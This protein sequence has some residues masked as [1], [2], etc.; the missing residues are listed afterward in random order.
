MSWFGQGK[1][2]DDG[3]AGSNGN[4]SGDQKELFL[5]GAV[6]DDSLTEGRGFVLLGGAQQSG[7][8]T[9]VSVGDDG[10]SY[11]ASGG[12]RHLAEVPDLLP[13]DDQEIHRL[14]FQHH[15][16]RYTMRGNFAAPISQ[17]TSILDV[18]CGTGRWAIEMAGLFPTANVIGLDIVPPSTRVPGYAERLPENFLFVNGN[19]F[20]RLPFSDGSFDFVHMRLLFTAIP[21]QRWPQVLRELVRITRAGG[22][23]ELVEGALPRNGGA[24]MDAINQWIAEVSNRRGINVEIGAQIGAFLQQAGLTG[25][26]SRDIYLPIGR[27]GGRAGQMTA[28]DTFAMYEGLRSLVAAQGITSQQEFDR[29]LSAARMEVDVG[30]RQAVR[31]FYLAYG[32]RNW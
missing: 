11:V 24:A 32:M 27:Y 25:I 17:P 30:G 5:P 15:L 22:W 28:A 14:D 19:V 20:E 3:T 1:S 7:E 29:A 10:R 4:K 21:A 26:V 2:K 12:R 9:Q 6:A 23:V 31:P 13:K 18:G 8:V 16:L